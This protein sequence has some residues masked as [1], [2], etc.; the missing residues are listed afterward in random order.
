MFKFF[1]SI[2]VIGTLL[3]ITNSYVYNGDANSGKRFAPLKL[4]VRKFFIKFILVCAL[5]ILTYLG[6]LAKSLEAAELAAH[7]GS[8][9]INSPG[10]IITSIFPSL[11]GFGIGVYAL[12][13]ALDK[14]VVK[15]FQ[16]AYSQ[17]EEMKSGS[18][19]VLSS[20][21]AY[22]LIILVLTLATGIFQIVFFNGFYICIFTWFM[23]WYSFIVII[24]MLGVLFG[25]T[26]NSLLDKL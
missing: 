20:D 19:L 14:S 22:P 9:A 1:R 3:L 23:L 8:Y 6:A 24:E 18:V 13:F 25:L 12:I 7:I 2:P 17:S 11:I 21:L 15:E 5:T 10:T 4:W 26:N 16:T